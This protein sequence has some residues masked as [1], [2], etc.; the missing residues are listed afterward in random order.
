M[1]KVGDYVRYN[2]VPYIIDQVRFDHEIEYLLVSPEEPYVEQKSDEGTKFTRDGD[3]I[4]TFGLVFNI[5]K[6][7]E[8]EL[9]LVPVQETQWIREDKLVRYEE[10]TSQELVD[11][12]NVM[13]RMNLYM[14][15]NIEDPQ[16]KLNTIGKMTKE[17]CEA[18]ANWDMKY[19]A[20]I[21]QKANEELDRKEKDQLIGRIVLYRE[22][23]YVV[24]SFCGSL[25]YVVPHVKHFPLEVY[26]EEPTLED[27]RE[28]DGNLY[29]AKH[30]HP[31]YRKLE[32]LISSAWIDTK[33]VEVID[34]ARDVKIFDSILHDISGKF[35]K[36]ARQGILKYR[37][38]EQ[39]NGPEDQTMNDLLKFPTMEKLSGFI[40]EYHSS[41][42][43]HA[44]DIYEKTKIG[45]FEKQN[46]CDAY[47][48]CSLDGWY[49]PIGSKYPLIKEALEMD[50]DKFEIHNG[51]K[52]VLSVPLT[53]E[54]VRT[55]LFADFH[56]FANTNIFSDTEGVKQLEEMLKI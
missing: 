56:K 12:N 46:I 25:I 20:S 24:L 14:A 51:K 30:T 16:T 13:K 44:R 10:E 9:Y 45:E 33:E 47:I 2:D 49:E 22:Q 39:H 18:V 50:D 1:Y 19:L 26:D 11:M 48:H 34:G 29:L 42:K 35:V 31:R 40:R 52:V 54:D 53:S 38:W 8:T 15:T 23:K 55:F 32:S 21:V 41:F 36:L 3:F 6:E 37:C 28:I 7:T 4:T 17:M 5:A 43:Y 27:L